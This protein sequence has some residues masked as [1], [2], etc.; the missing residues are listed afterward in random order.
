MP[1]VTPPG[2]LTRRDMYQMGWTL[3]LVRKLLPKAD[4]KQEKA[5]GYIRME[6]ALYRKER[7]EA[8]M[9]TEEFESFQ[10]KRRL[11]LEAPIRR[12]AMFERVYKNWRAALPD[13][14]IGLHSLNRY[15][16]HA[17]CSLDNRTEIYALKNQMVELLYQ[18]GYCTA[19]WIHTQVLPAKVCREC[20]GTSPR[21]TGDDYCDRCANT[22]EYLPAKTLRFYVFKFAIGRGYTWHQPDNLV[23]FP[24]DVTREPEAWSGIEREK[25]LGMARSQLGAAKGLLRWVMDKAKEAEPMV[26]HFEVGVSVPLKGIQDGLF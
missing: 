24:V 8:A 14:C 4:A 5:R 9:A 19:C 23:K 26:E 22:G 3:T 12:A 11:K 6:I 16:K 7:V 25:P 15:A 1:V 2:F 20:M 18:K 17:T 21:Y 13:A 10:E